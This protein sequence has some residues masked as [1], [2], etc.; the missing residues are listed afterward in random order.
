MA[1]EVVMPKLGAT[2]EE[3][4]IVSW[5]VNDGEFIEEGDPIAEIQTDKIVLEV[6]AES[7]GHLLKKLYD[8]G[9]TV[10]VHEVIAYMGEENE[11]IEQTENF[12]QSKDNKLEEVNEQE[13][14]RK[15]PAANKLA[16]D[17]GVDLSLVSGTGPNSRV[18]K[19]DVENYLQQ[20]TS[21]ITPLAQKMV[22]DL[23]IDDKDLIGSGQHGKITK[24]DVLSAVTKTTS[25]SER[26]SSQLKKVPLKG[27]RK[28]IAERMSES[29][30]TAPHV[31]LTTEINMTEC[32][33]LRKQLLPVIEKETGYRLS[34]NDLIV[35]AVAHTLSKNKA[36]NISLQNNEIYFYEEVN[37]GFAVS[38]DEGLVVPVIENTDQIGLAEIVKRSKEIV[39]NIKN[40]KLSPEYFENG[41]FTISN[42]GMYAVDSFTPIIN[43]PQSAILGVGR[44][45]E[46]PVVKNGEVVINSMMQL[47][48]SFDHRVID[49]APAA[50]FMTD[51]KENLENPF[52]MLV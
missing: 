19:Q 39:A 33:I 24:K 41:T 50:Q 23:K 21:K 49:G 29:Y 31:T 8:A 25:A 42:L 32:V 3:G 47:S 44:I 13:K 2:M 12:S 27:M 15:T 20:D 14:V 17:N 52:R 16:K 43:Q 26:E 36:L 46:K 1:R 35:K 51:L 5:L 18:Q 45:V 38:L 40:G 22:Q 48:L 11:A 9:S 28:V 30:Y 37:I 7:S 10:K 34:Y 6:E 4:I